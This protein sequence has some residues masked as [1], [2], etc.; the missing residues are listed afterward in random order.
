MVASNV[1][2]NRSCRL[3]LLA[4]SQ[5]DWMGGVGVAWLWVDRVTGRASSGRCRR[6][7][8]RLQTAMWPRVGAL[9]HHIHSTP[10]LRRCRPWRCTVVCSDH[11]PRAASLAPLPQRGPL[12]LH[13]HNYTPGWRPMWALHQHCSSPAPAVKCA[14][15]KIVQVGPAGPD[16]LT[17]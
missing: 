2:E 5:D 1:C 9:A 16:C 12:M 13:S 8:Q 7:P 14:C 4:R 11:G 15:Y 17:Q 10:G 6:A 3:D